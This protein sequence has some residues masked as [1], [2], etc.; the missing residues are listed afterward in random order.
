VITEPRHMPSL[1]DRIAAAHRLEMP[2]LVRACIIGLIVALGSWCAPAAAGVDETGAYRTDVRV[3]V[4]AFRGLEPRIGFSY[5]SRAA[6]GVAGVEWRLDASSYIVRAGPAG[7]VP[8]YDD[9]DV[10]VLDGNELARPRAF[11]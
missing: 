3:E 7:A 1:F 5:N 8:R 4:P 10:F 11:F 6:N 2:V 9:G